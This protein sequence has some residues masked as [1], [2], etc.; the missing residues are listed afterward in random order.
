MA[1]F[2]GTN[3]YKAG[4]VVFI[5]R[6][7]RPIVTG[8]AS[9][10]YQTIG[11]IAVVGRDPILDRPSGWYSVELGDGSGASE[12]LHHSALSLSPHTIPEE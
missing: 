12:T 10:L 5:R 2:D 1:T 6:I 7:A 8:R 3:P 11:T 4:D 9:T